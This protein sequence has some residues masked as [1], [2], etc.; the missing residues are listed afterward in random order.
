MPREANRFQ[1]QLVDTEHYEIK[2]VKC[3][4]PIKYM[5]DSE[6]VIMW[7]IDNV[8]WHL[9]NTCY[10]DVMQGMMEFYQVFLVEKRKQKV[11]N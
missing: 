9:H 6:H 1:I 4:T 2:C 8:A 11:T 10:E 3:A 7:P 5:E